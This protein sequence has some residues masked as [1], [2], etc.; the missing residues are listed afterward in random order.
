LLQVSVVS[1]QVPLVCM[2]T[3]TILVSTLLSLKMVNRWN[4][5]L[6]RVNNVDDKCKHVWRRTKYNKNQY[7]LKKYD[8]PFE[9]MEE[10]YVLICCG[11]CTKKMTV[12]STFLESSLNFLL[13]NL[14]KHYKLG[15]VREKNL[16]CQKPSICN[17]PVKFCN[18]LITLLK[19]K[20]VNLII[21][22][23]PCYILFTFCQNCS[24]LKSLILLY[25]LI[26]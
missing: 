10:S 3:Q 7:N 5:D 23:V 12:L 9:I 24:N 8:T 1:C 14:K 11:F 22:Y 6:K 20:L 21:V 18:F 13:N 17:L 2:A 26:E 15:T 25:V 16:N 19:K 4:F